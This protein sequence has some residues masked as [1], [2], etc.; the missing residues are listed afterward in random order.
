MTLD[1]D[2]LAAG[3]ESVEE[4]VGLIRA[5]DFSPTEEPGPALCRDCPARARL[6]PYPPEVTMG[7]ATAVAGA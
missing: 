4:L 5:G 1:A 6:C 2:A 7:G 3:R